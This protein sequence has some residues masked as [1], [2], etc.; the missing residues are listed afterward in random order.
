MSLENRIRN[1]IKTYLQ[2]AI[3]DKAALFVPVNLKNKNTTNTI[4]AIRI[5]LLI[6]KNTKHLST[7]TGA[8]FSE[9]FKLN[10]SPEKR[11]E[12]RSATMNGTIGFAFGIGSNPDSSGH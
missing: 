10:P 3:S 1:S 11:F 4:I 9:A 7:M 8:K 12:H 2:I 6:P 5:C